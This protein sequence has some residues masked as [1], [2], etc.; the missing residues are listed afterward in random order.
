MRKFSLYLILLLCL[1]LSACAAPAVTPASITASTATLIPSPTATL[2]PSPTVT[3]EPSATIEP[4]PTALPFAA[5]TFKTDEKTGWVVGFD[6]AGQVVGVAVDGVVYPAEGEF[7]PVG[8]NLYRYDGYQFIEAGTAQTLETGETFMTV[9]NAET[10][11]PERVMIPGTTEPIVNY[12]RFRFFNPDGSRQVYKWKTDANGGHW[13]PAPKLEPMPLVERFRS[14]DEIRS[15]MVKSRYGGI[16]IDDMPKNGYGLADF[17]GYLVGY[18]LRVDQN[19]E[20]ISTMF[21]VSHGKLIAIRPHI[22][23][24]LDDR[25][26]LGDYPLS[27]GGLDQRDLSHLQALMDQAVDTL[28]PMNV[29]LQAYVLYDDRMCSVSPV[30]KT[31]DICMKVATKQ[32]SYDQFFADMSGVTLTSLSDNWAGE[33]IALFDVVADEYYF[34]A[35]FPKLRKTG[36]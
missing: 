31:R 7:I 16:S 29:T 14:E 17:L 30:G 3:P 32:T 25:Q 15:L 2:F 5:E 20:V 10:G 24:E 6:E 33:L 19:N 28:G 27:S 26:P 13:E 12:D 35:R 18:Q 22:V 9:V 11:M 36:D 23:S 1:L 4:T 8:E 34:T 21:L